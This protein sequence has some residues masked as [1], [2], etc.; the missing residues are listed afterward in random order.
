MATKN[1]TLQSKYK[2]LSGQEI[3]ILGF[4]VSSLLFSEEKN[5]LSHLATRNPNLT[6]SFEHRFT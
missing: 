5:T 4:G 2:L 1:Q 6:I 3:P